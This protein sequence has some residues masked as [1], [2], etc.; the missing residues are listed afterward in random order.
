MENRGY[1]DLILTYLK[2]T[3]SV[4]KLRRKPRTAKRCS[5]RVGIGQPGKTLTGLAGLA[6]VEELIGRLGIVEVLNRG[7]GSIK[8]RDRGLSGGQ[9]LMRMATAQL[10]GQDCLA[11]MDRVRADAGSALLTEA[12]VAPSRTAARLAGRFGPA[13]LVGIETSLSELYTRWLRAVPA[14]VRAP[15]VLHDPTIDL[16]ASDI[17]VHGPT[18]QG[19]GWNYAGV[20]SGRVHLASW[21]QAELPLAADLMA[22]NDD[23][24]PGAGRLLARA[25]NSM[26]AQVC[27]RPRVRADAGYS[28]A[29]LAHAAVELG[30]DFAIAAK[31]NSAAWRAL[32]AVPEADWRDARGMKGAQVAACDYTPAGWPDGT[33]TIIR[34]SRSKSTSSAPTRAP[35]AAGPSRKTSSPS[36]SAAPPTTSGRSASSSP[37]SPPTTATTS[38]WKR[39]SATAPRSRNASVRSSTAQASTTSR[40]PTQ[41]S[42]TSGSGPGCWPAR[43]RSCCNR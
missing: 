1:E 28:G 42:T 19:V 33:Y 30:C 13:Q 40:Q 10:L 16:D 8:Q 31:R 9:L 21:A 27:G 15:L 18:K 41:A 14:Q 20:R 39:G 24:R 38:G 25:L 6:A 5:R 35:G 3:C 4:N 2:G 17:E 43:C 29:T 22:G 7:I 36:P 26:P 34:R 23:V 32:S 11:G 37:T 12:P